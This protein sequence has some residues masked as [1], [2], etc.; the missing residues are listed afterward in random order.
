[1]IVYVYLL[2]DFMIC[3]TTLCS[4]HVHNIC[5]TVLPKEAKKAR[6]AEK[7]AKKLAKLQN[8]G[9]DDDGDD[10][11][12]ADGEEGDEDEVFYGAPDDH[13]WTDASHA[14][15]ESKDKKDD[16][17]DLSVS[18]MMC[19]AESCIL[20]SPVLEYAISLS[21]PHHFPHSSY[22]DPTAKS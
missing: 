10:D 3:S 7:E 8:K 11:G 21:P 14:I 22:T 13:A 9:E 20:A 17:P 1:M 16:G 2:K 5:K 15:K 12:K 6:K 4:H 18:I 19:S